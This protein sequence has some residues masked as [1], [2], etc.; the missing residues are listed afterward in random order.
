VSGDRQPALAGAV[1]LCDDRPMPTSAPP[2][3]ATAAELVR[4]TVEA[5]GRQDLAAARLAWADDIVERFPDRTCR[6]VEELAAYFQEAY[7][8][9][10]DWGFEALAVV[11]EGEDVLVQWRLTGTHTGPLLGIAATGRPLEI[12]GMDHFVVR[13]GRIVSNFVVFD[14]MQYARQLGMMPPDGSSAD[15]ALKGAFNARTKLLD[16]LRNR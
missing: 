6:G 2:A 9:I 11:G 5:I 15:R 1:P 13:D 10:S 14:Q 8:A 3:E 16:R 7:D 4:W 12:D